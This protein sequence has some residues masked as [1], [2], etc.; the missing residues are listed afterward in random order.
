MLIKKWQDIEEYDIGCILGKPDLG[1][2]V[3]RISGNLTDGKSIKFNFNVEHYILESGK[4]YNVTNNQHAMIVYVI[5]GIAS[6]NGENHSTEAY[7]GDIVYLGYRELHHIDNI[8]KEPLE[9]LCCI[10]SQN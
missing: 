8:S 1:V 3:K 4:S 9:I 10:N 6:F 5:S 7:K 2:K